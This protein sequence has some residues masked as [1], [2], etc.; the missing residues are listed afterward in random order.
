MAHGD[1]DGGA[2]HEGGNGGQRDELDD[3]AAPDQADGHDDDAA[4][5]GQT[6]GHLVI[7]V[8]RM[9]STDLPHHVADNFRHDRHGLASC[10]RGWTVRV[11]THAHEKEI[12][13]AD[14]DILG[15]GE[16]PV[17][18]DPHEGRVQAELRI[19]FSETGVGHGLGHHHRAHR[20][21]YTH[22]HHIV[23]ILFLA[24]V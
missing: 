5:D 10:Q 6:R 24:C 16:K 3:P 14:G 4:Y 15:G 22:T 7:G 1:V 17:N 8:F 20:N 2:G 19:Q 21:S 18:Q 12:T 9:L 11:G 23:S 13:H